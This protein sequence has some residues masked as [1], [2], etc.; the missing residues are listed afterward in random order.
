MSDRFPLVPRYRLDD[1][2]TWL[3]GID[4]LRRYWLLVNGDEAKPIILPGLSTHDFDQFRQAIL[5]FRG[6]V[7]GDTLEL[8]TA[9]GTALAIRCASKNCFAIDFE[10]NGHPATHLF[11]QEALE[12]LLMTAHPDWQCAPHHRELGRQTLS[13]SWHQPA[14]SKTAA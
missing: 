14:A 4:P 1:E 7:A 2:Q 13:L 6:L 12:S 3:V 10:V 9:T 8:P 11:D 5:A